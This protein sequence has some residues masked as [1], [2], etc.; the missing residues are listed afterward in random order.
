MTQHVYTGRGAPSVVDPSLGAHYLDLDSGQHFLFNGAAWQVGGGGGTSSAALTVRTAAMEPNLFP[1]AE[2][3]TYSIFEGSPA[4]GVITLDFNQGFDPNTTPVSENRQ[5]N[6]VFRD[7]VAVEFYFYTANIVLLTN[8]VS[9]TPPSAQQSNPRL[10]PSN[11]AR[12]MVLRMTQLGK[13]QAVRTLLI[14]ASAIEALI[15]SATM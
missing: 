7:H 5:V 1:G 6:W 14:E 12:G 9:Y 15:P 11:P 4:G 2:S 10:E 13:N 8:G 3:E